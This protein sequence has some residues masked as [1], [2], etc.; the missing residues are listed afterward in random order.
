[1]KREG[2]QQMALVVEWSGTV[3]ID[4]CLKFE[5][6]VFVKITHFLFRSVWAKN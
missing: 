5:L 1:M 6:G 2:V 3:T 4:V